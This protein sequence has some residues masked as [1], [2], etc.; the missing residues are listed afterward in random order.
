M[1][2]KKHVKKNARRMTILSLRCSTAGRPHTHV[3][4]FGSLLYHTQEFWLF[5][6]R[7]KKR[8]LTNDDHF[9]HLITNDDQRAQRT[10][11]A[12][13]PNQNARSIE[14]WCILGPG[15]FWLDLMKQSPRAHSDWLR[16][17]LTH[18]VTHVIIGLFGPENFWCF[19]E[20]WAQKIIKISFF[21]WAQNKT[22]RC[23]CVLL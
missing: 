10:I 21:L 9:G 18:W 4:Y 12:P 16:G 5:R 14:A 2:K 22:M 19:S 11:R 15:P 1:K 7:W 17:L 3:Y 20:L 8:T 23:V 13:G 6:C